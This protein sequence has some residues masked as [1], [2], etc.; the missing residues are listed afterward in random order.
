MRRQY[1]S[2]GNPLLQMLRYTTWMSDTSGRDSAHVLHSSLVLIKRFARVRQI[3]ACGPHDSKQVT[4]SISIA[5]SLPQDIFA[6]HSYEPA[7][8]TQDEEPKYMKVY[9]EQTRRLWEHRASFGLVILDID[10][11]HAA[12]VPSEEGYLKLVFSRCDKRP[13]LGVLFKIHA[14]QSDAPHL[15]APSSMRRGRQPRQTRARKRLLFT[16]DY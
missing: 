11:D 16:D 10:Y 14:T 6:S 1:P 13:H 9:T 7:Q 3:M 4:C 2:M 8:D 12:F 15:T 5:F